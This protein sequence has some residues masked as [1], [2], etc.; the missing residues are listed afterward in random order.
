MNKVKISIV[1]LFL[2]TLI[3]CDSRTYDEISGDSENPTYTKNIKPIFDS[4]CSA[5]HFSGN[6]DGLSSFSN[7]A[8]TRQGVEFGD[9][10]Y[11]VDT[12]GTMPKN[13]T[14][15]PNETIQ[16]LYNWKEDGYPEN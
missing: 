6:P 9:V 1:F 16:L 14:K 11:Y 3:S 5:C 15:L 12:L 7:Y 2:I 8:E 4:K 13:S 10:L